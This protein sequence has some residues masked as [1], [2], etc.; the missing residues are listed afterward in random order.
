VVKCVRTI[1]NGDIMRK[2]SA[3]TFSMTMMGVALLS[4]GC[5]DDKAKKEAAEAPVQAAEVAP[6]AEPVAP[7]ATV[8]ETTTVEAAPAEVAPA[9]AAPAAEAK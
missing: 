3:L 1:T 5:W 8:V 6:A 7:V 4:S 9:E 2:L